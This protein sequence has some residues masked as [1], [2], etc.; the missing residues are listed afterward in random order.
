[1][2]RAAAA[3][4]KPQQH[5]AV[6]HRGHKLSPLIYYLATIVCSISQLR[7]GMA[8]RTNLGG[9]ADPDAGETARM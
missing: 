6:Q 1:V 8:I 3:V 4:K 5:H 7:L 2:S 9:D